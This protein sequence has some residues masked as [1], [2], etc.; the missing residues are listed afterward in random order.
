MKLQ[1]YRSL[2]FCEDNKRYNL[3]KITS[4]T[5]MQNS[6]SYVFEKITI[7]M[8]VKDNNCCDYTK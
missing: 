2:L 4:D 1:K 6:G 7:D 3:R 5:I 8:L